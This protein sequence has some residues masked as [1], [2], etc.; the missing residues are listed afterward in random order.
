MYLFQTSYTILS[1]NMANTVLRSL[2]YSA[3][4]AKSVYTCIIPIQVSTV[5]LE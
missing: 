4:C 3:E 5:N 1:L 2:K